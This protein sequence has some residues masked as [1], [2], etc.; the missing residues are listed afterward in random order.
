[1]PQI[2]LPSTNSCLVIAMMKMPEIST[3]FMVSKTE[4]TSQDKQVQD[5]TP[6]QPHI[7]RTSYL[8]DITSLPLFLVALTCIA[9]CIVIVHVADGKIV[10]PGRPARFSD[11]QPTVLVALLAAVFGFCVK[12]VFASGVN[13]VWWRAFDRH[14]VRLAD[15]HYI[16][17]R[18]TPE[19]FKD[20]RKA[21]NSKQAKLILAVFTIVSAV[22]LSDGPL[23]QRSIRSGLSNHTSEYDSS[24]TIAPN[25]TD[26]WAGTIDT[27]SPAEL[28][29]SVDLD[30]VLQKWYL[31]RSLEAEGICE[32]TCNGSLKA[33]GIDVN[34]TFSERDEDLTDPQS[35]D[36]TLYSVSFNRTL[37]AKGVPVLDMTHT[38]MHEVDQ[39]CK[40]TIGVASCSIQTA[41]VQYTIL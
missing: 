38:F 26:G 13:I 31:N 12:L 24:W 1:M 6:P 15:L 36:A 9:G 2:R 30:L 39:S 35:V 4:V 41:N 25:I 7:K 3:P 16:F 33:A 10:D 19:G 21:L 27:R 18:G 17:K 23:L 37:D 20:I 5:P 40:S 34:C 32:G 29:G 11:V 8:P 14:D 28:A 22:D